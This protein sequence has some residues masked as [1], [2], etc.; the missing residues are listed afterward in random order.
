MYENN[1]W[2]DKKT[3]LIFLISLYGVQSKGNYYFNAQQQF[4]YFYY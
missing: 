3:N 1:N 4:Y 2:E